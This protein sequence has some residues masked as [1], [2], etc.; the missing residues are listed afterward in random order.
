VIRRALER[1]TAAQRLLRLTAQ[2][3][4]LFRVAA[5]SHRWVSTRSLVLSNEIR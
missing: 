2:D 5:D 1:G 4:C 3:I